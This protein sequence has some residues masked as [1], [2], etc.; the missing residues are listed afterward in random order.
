VAMILG[1]FVCCNGVLGRIAADVAASSEHP[2]ERD[3]TS[4]A[5]TAR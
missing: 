2:R 5:G 1:A 4:V 3:P